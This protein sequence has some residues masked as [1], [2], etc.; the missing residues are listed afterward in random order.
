MTLWALEIEYD[1][2]PFMGWQRQKHGLAIQQV[3]EE[4]AARVRG[5]AEVTE[6]VSAGRTDA[7]VHAMGM[8]VQIELPELTPFRIREAMNFHLKPN[9]IVVLRCCPAPDGWNAR[10]SAT[11]RSY[12]YIISN[13]AVP[14][15]LE[16]GRVWHVRQKLD[17]GLMHD[18]AQ[19]LL[20]HHDF[21]SFRASAC[22]AKSPMRTLDFLA[23]TR[24]GDKIYVETRARSFLHHQVRNMVGSLVKVGEGSWPAPKLA[25]VLDAKSRAAA[26]VT[27]PAEGLY[28]TGVVYDPALPLE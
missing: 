11:S 8:I 27:A 6:A 25:E 7:G 23:V 2:R 20:G 10:F 18:A 19:T 1:G 12:R 22:Q 21:S 5:G 14:P 13:R 24:E 3:V 9:P 26:S 17:A 4:A 28:F 15:A 16:A